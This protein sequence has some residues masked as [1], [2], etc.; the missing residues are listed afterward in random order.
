VKGCWGMNQA[1]RQKLS[2]L[3]VGKMHSRAGM[4]I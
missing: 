3:F 2:S 4:T 1:S